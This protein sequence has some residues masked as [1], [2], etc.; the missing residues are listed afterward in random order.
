MGSHF[1]N[2]FVHRHPF[3]QKISKSSGIFLN[4]ALGHALLP[5]EEDSVLNKNWEIEI[6]IWSGPE[7]ILDVGMC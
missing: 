4:I 7:I 1:P 6:S 2:L 5:L 3:L